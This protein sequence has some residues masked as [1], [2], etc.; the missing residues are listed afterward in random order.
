M[1]RESYPFSYINI[2]NLDYNSSYFGIIIDNT[3]FRVQNWEINTQKNFWN[4]ILLYV[5]ENIEKN[6]CLSINIDYLDGIRDNEHDTYLIFKCNKNSSNSLVKKMCDLLNQK[7]YKDMDKFCI[8]IPDDY[9]LKRQ[10]SDPKILL[11]KILELAKTKEKEEYIMILEQY[12]EI[13]NKN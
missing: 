11:E 6:D 4:E 3:D 9:K 7:Y 8:D 1:N 12:Q 5:K 2:Y 10:F 13:M